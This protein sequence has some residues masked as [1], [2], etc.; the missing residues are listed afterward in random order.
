MSKSMTS[1]KT[2]GSWSPD[3]K[4]VIFETVAVLVEMQ[5]AY[6][7]EINIKTLLRGWEVLLSDRFTGD[8]ICFAC[9]QYMLKKDDI[10][11]V[12][13]LIEILE[14][15]KKGVSYAEYQDALEY[16]RKNGYPQFSAAQ[17]TIREY[18]NQEHEIS[19]ELLLLSAK[20]Q[21]LG[22]QKPAE[23]KVL[24]ISDNQFKDRRESKP[25]IDNRQIY[26]AYPIKGFSIAMVAPLLNQVV[27]SVPLEDLLNE[28]KENPPECEI[29]E[30]LQNK[31]AECS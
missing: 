14:P 20:R 19:Q 18:K 8:E 5:K 28:L 6:G 21:E 27:K 22:H 2:D 31:L 15:K 11:T 1:E 29:N 7:K 23:N 17:Y 25:I 4:K 10:P 12:S 30:W 26:Q 16:Q 13:N 24:E 9:K 3:E